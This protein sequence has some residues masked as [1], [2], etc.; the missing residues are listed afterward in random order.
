MP[1]VEKP[2]KACF[3]KWRKIVGWL[4]NQ[5]VVTKMD[6]GLHYD[7]KW[8][9]SSDRTVL[10]IAEL[11]VE[12]QHIGRNENN[13]RVLGLGTRMQNVEHQTWANVLGVKHNLKTMI[14][15]ILTPE[16]IIE[17]DDNMNDETSEGISNR[18]MYAVADAS[19]SHNQMG[20]H[21]KIM[22]V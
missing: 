13:R 2:S 4:R 15:S 12:E 5:E 11:D 17:E 14:H 8:Q 18:K 7:S 16:E 22:D 6:F 10:K 1:I 19:I 20:G 21:W 9:M 3:R